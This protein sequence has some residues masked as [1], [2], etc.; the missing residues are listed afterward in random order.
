GNKLV[1]T[2]ST[3]LGQ[4]KV[5]AAD[6]VFS[7]QLPSMVNNIKHTSAGTIDQGKGMVTVP[8]QTKSVTITLS[9]LPN[10]NSGNN[11]NNGSSGNNGN[12]N[13][14]NNNNNGNNGS[15]GNGGNEKP[16]QQGFSDIAKHWGREAIEKA[17]ERGIVKG[18]E[19][20]TFRPNAKVTRSELMAMLA[21][22]LKLPADETAVSFKDAASIPAWAKP[23]VSSVVKAGLVKGYEDQS[24]RPGQTITRMELVSIVARALE[25]KGSQAALPFVDADDIPAWG[26]EAAAAVY[27]AGLIQGKNQRFAPNDAVTRAEAVTLLLRMAP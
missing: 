16:E 15:N 24:F 26:R 7:I 12:S 11:G 2:F 6:A 23:Y 17:V 20:S 5:D 1:F 10:D 27:E 18:Y 14:G 3:S 8:L 25:L 9:D 19:D 21:R 4:A 22:T 13:N